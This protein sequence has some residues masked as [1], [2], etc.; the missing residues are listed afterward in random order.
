MAVTVK[1]LTAKE[2]G[3][4]RHREGL[5]VAAAVKEAKVFV[6]AGGTV[7]VYQMEGRNVVAE[8]RVPLGDLATALVADNEIVVTT[9]PVSNG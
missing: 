4:V 1:S 8:R 9:P 2:S 5:T 6:P 7:T 3:Q